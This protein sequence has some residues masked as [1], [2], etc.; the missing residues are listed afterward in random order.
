[1]HA[2][3]SATDDAQRAAFARGV[4][5]ILVPCCVGKLKEA[6]DAAGPRSRWL[7]NA[8]GDG[9]SVEFLTLASAADHKP[10]PPPPPLSPPDAADD[11]ASRE[12]RT[13]RIT[14]AKD[15]VEADRSAAAVSENQTRHVGS[16]FDEDVIRF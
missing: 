6:G 11:G 7:K 9:G 10:P 8:L 14:T 16:M 12:L 5:Y 1:M 4:G 13:F 15:L 3:G 2:C